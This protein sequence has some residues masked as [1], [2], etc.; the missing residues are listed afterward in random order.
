MD[1]QFCPLGG[2]TE[3]ASPLFTIAAL[4][5]AG[6][7]RRGGICLMDLRSGLITAR[8]YSQSGQG[9]SIK[10]SP[11]HAELLAF[12]KSAFEFML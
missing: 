6:V 1:H 12:I 8:H 9:R 10:W 4:T 7:Q 3:L 5:Q 11:R 2:A